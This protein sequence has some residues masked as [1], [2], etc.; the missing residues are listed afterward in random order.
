[1]ANGANI[2]LSITLTLSL[3]QWA[4]EPDIL[5]PGCTQPP[6]IH[7]ALSQGA[8]VACMPVAYCGA[9]RLLP[10]GESGMYA[11]A[12]RADEGYPDLAPALDP[13]KF[14]AISQGWR[15]SNPP[16]RDRGQGANQCCGGN[17]ATHS[18]RISGVGRDRS[19]YRSLMR[20]PQPLILLLWR[21]VL[22]HQAHQML[23]HPCFDRRVVYRVLLLW[24]RLQVEQHGV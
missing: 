3:S 15:R 4:R 22:S 6:G 7:A 19:G 21:V 9:Y 8:R 11:G 16:P 20:Q 23:D 24:V 10:P 17:K 14:S 2:W 1:M 18:G 5:T 12:R 13:R